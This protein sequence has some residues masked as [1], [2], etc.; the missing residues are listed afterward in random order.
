MLRHRT[1]MG[2]AFGRGFDMGA[3]TAYFQARERAAGHFFQRSA[4]RDA[5]HGFAQWATE[6]WQA[7]GKH[8]KM[9]PPMWLLQGQQ[10]LREQE[11]F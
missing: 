11:Q 9:L 7:H 1:L 5:G 2:K 3:Q 6:Y 8:S 4:G 10:L